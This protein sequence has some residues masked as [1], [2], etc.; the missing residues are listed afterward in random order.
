MRLSRSLIFASLL[1]VPLHSALAQGGGGGGA[2]GSGGS[3]GGAGGAAGGTS[4]TAGTTGSPAANPGVV[5]DTLNRSNPNPTL[6]QTGSGNSTQPAMP[7]TNSVGTAQSSGSS[8]GSGS[9][10]SAGGGS[11]NTG[12]T[13]ATT[14]MAGNRNGG[15]IDGVVTQGPNKPGDVEIRA[16]NSKVNQKIKSICRGC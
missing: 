14:G 16:E 5:G 8:A 3:A 7:G 10:S 2:G 4:G 12:N 9:G 15:R 11:T 1:L 6:N 13:S